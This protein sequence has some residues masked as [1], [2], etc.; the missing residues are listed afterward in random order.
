MIGRVLDGR[1]RVIDALGSGSFSQTYIAEDIR[2]PG[3]PK[4]V[5]KYLQPD[6]NTPKQLATAN[7]LFKSEAE[8]LEKLGKHDQ[9]PQLF[10]YI[11]EEF[12]LVQEFIQGHPLSIELPPG[13]RWTEGKVLQL[14]I[15]VLQTLEYVHQQSVIHR[16]LK[17]EN[18]IR[19][20]SDGKIVLIDFGA[21]KQIQ[22][23]LVAQTQM[24]PTVA[25]GTAG[26]SPSEQGQ[27]RPR[28]NSDLYALG[29][30]AVQALTGVHPTE[31]QEDP[32]TGEIL[33]QHLAPRT[34]NPKL[35][36]VITKL[37]RYHFKDRYSTA[38]E[39]L[40]AARALQ[41]A[42]KNRRWNLTIGV[43]AIALML[44]TSI[45]L[46]RFFPSSET[47][48]EPPT[49]LP[50]EPVSNGVDPQTIETEYETLRDALNRQD[51]ETADRA[52]YALMLSIAG[53]KSKQQGRFDMEEWRNFNCD[54]WRRIDQLWRDKTNNNQ[55]F[56]IQKEILNQILPKDREPTNEDYHRYY[57]QIGWKDEQNVLVQVQYDGQ[58][59]A[60][61]K[62][63]NFKNP[64]RGHLPAKML[65]SEKGDHRFRT[66][67]LP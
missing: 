2:R 51:L 17:P 33:W 65:W 41:P 61:L 11:E 53:L 14:L 8:T 6:T 5:V 40:S 30:I 18:L 22:Q 39:A 54:E 27:G 56:S 50:A 64:K 45:L 44:L 29:M 31:F 20:Q 9:I 48:V 21:V 10:A 19:R 32:Q 52:T 16:D 37:V 15:D 55:G 49:P 62:I 67:C 43:G 13:H 4:C 25:I 28:P 3:T 38:T 60:Y 34:L 47:V 26:Y 23:S 24:N 58:S 36:D 7:R 46:L 57:V 42:L 1:Y 66:S 12:C 35:A 63:P 59:V